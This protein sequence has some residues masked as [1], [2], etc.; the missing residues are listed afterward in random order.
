MK[1]FFKFVKNLPIIKGYIQKEVDKN[2]KGVEEGFQRGVG[3]LTYIKTLPKK[4]LSEVSS[5]NLYFIIMHF[6]TSAN[7]VDSDQTASIGA[8]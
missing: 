8:V 5:F 7:T 3:K 1:S 2:A 4:G 6:Y